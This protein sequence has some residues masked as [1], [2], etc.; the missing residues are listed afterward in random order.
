MRRLITI[1]AAVAAI[2]AFSTSTIPTANAKGKYCLVQALGGAKNCSYP[3]KAACEK[4]KGS[5]S[6]FCEVY[7]GVARKL[8]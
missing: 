8:R 4:V 3:T 5:P 1:S 6:D 2:A 7:G